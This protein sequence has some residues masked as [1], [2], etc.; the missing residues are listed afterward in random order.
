VWVV[1]KDGLFI[2]GGIIDGMWEEE[3]SYEEDDEEDDS[4]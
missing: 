1:L 4:N 3:D 2:A